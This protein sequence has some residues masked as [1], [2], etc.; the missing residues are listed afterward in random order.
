MVFAD[1]YGFM[2][3]DANDARLA[4]KTTARETYDSA[5]RTA[6]QHGAFDML[7]FNARGELTEGGRTNVFVRIGRRWYTPPLACG[8]LPGVMRGVLLEDPAW[9]ATERVLSRDDVLKAEHIVLC[10]ALRGPLLAN[11]KLRAAPTV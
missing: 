3:T 9:Q 2:P 6:E 1:D 4:H 5:W 10:N 11:L 8:L 7:F